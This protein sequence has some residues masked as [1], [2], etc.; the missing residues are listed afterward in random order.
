MRAFAAALPA[1]RALDLLINNAGVMAPPR[2]AD[3]GRLR[4]ASSAPTTSATSRSPGWLLG[5][6][7]AAPAP[8]VVTL[9]SDAHRI[10]RIDFDDLQSERRYNNW[11]AYG[12]SKLANLMFCFELERRAAAAGTALLSVAAHPDTRP[13]TSS[14]PGREAAGADA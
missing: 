5:Q 1:S 12:Q 14:S 9:S 3:R 2:R 13:P 6:L 8:R 4:D 11:L 10:G 7:L